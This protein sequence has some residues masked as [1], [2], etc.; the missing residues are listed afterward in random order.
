MLT[1]WVQEEPE[2]MGAWEYISKNMK[3]YDIEPVCRMASG[4]PAVGLH[5]LHTIGQNE[6]INKVFRRCDCELQ[7]VYCGLQ[8]V[9]G[10]SR[11]E[12]MKQ[13]RYIFRRRINSVLCKLFSDR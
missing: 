9:I 4:S 8:C 5:E 13:H 7:N 2:N 11:E 6:I 12:I 3:T 1:L 10:K